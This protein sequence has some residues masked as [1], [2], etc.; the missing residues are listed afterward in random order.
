MRVPFL[1]KYKTSEDSKEKR[2]KVKHNQEENNKARIKSFGQGKD[3][4][5][6]FPVFAFYT[7]GPVM[8]FNKLTAKD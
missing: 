3:K 8:L 2:I 7:D 1:Q 4:S 5:A 6:S